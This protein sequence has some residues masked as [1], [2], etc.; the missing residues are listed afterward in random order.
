MR[1]TLSIDDDL[2]CAAK[3]LALARSVSVGTVISDLMRKGLS[4]PSATKTR[5]GLPLFALPPGARPL[6]LE[7]VKKAED[8]P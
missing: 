8:L 6:T 3:A 1:T 7:D 5:N 4:A 2:L